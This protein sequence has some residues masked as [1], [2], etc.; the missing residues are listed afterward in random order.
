MRSL[1]FF[2]LAPTLALATVAAAQDVK[3]DITGIPTVWT[4]SGV[5]YANTDSLA[6]CQ[7]SDGQHLL[8]A[9]AKDG[10][11][12]D[13]F[14]A[15]DGTFL[16]SVGEP[17]MGP[18][19]FMRPNG[20]VAVTFEKDKP[21]V[22]G[23]TRTMILVIERDGH[24]VQAIDPDTFKPAGIFGTN[25]L[26][27]PYGGAVSYRDNGIYLYVTETGVP[28]PHTVRV[29]RLTLRDGQVDG[30]LLRTFGEDKGPGIIGEAESIAIDDKAEHVYLC[31]EASKSVKVYSL[32]GKFTGTTF[33]AN[34]IAGDPEGIGLLDTREG[35]YVLVTDQRSTITYWHAFDREA[36]KYVCTLTGAPRIANTD[37]ICIYNAE[38]GPFSEGA[39]YAVNDDA[40]VRAY[41]LWTMRRIIETRKK[42]RNAQD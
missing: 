34:L 5:E 22:S 29:Y 8:F 18:G 36:H 30:K 40:D 13:V 28:K 7:R 41:K 3:L 26:K 14:D 4:S 21:G 38:F 33:G 1:V 20:V 2:V 31:D 35:Q 32:N 16:Q 42:L 25:E 27:R 23:P 19:Q 6:A 15:G 17:G 24:R 10:H 9:T 37:G 11:R 12:L 39:L